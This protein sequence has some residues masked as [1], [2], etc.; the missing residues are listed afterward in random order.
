M[1][2]MELFTDH[3]ELA[4]KLSLLVMLYPEWSIYGNWDTPRC[5]ACG[6]FKH[7]EYGGVD[8]G[9]KPDCLRKW[10]EEFVN[11]QRAAKEQQAKG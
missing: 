9:H 10:Y 7:R 8:A 4:R 11:E 3:K 5:I 6:G 2:Q 1:A